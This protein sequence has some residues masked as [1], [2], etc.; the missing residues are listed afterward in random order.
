MMRFYDLKGLVILGT[1]ALFLVMGTIPAQA[2]PIEVN[3]TVENLRDFFSSNPPPTDPVRGTIIYEAPSVTADIQSL[4]SIDLVID[5]HTYSKSEIGYISPFLGSRQL[6]GGNGAGVD[7]LFS[8]AN[9]FRLDWFKNTLMPFKFS[10][11]SSLHGGI[12]DSIDSNAFTS[13][14]VRESSPVPE[15]ATLLL[16]GSGLIGLAGLRRK[17]KK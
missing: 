2:I 17:S 1:V 8:G 13:F 9:D 10:Y 7:V 6:I 5:G 14:S 15:P 4:I 11:T 12:W 3:F 16:L